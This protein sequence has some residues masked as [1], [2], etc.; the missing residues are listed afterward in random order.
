MKI[1]TSTLMRF[2]NNDLPAKKM[3][4]IFKNVIKAIKKILIAPI[5]FRSNIFQASTG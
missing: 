4:E 5:V 2:L 3:Q 1:D